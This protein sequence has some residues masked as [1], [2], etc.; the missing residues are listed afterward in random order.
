MPLRG[1][2][3][4]SHSGRF[5]RIHAPFPRLSDFARRRRA[6][7]FAC[8]IGGAVGSSARSQSDD[9]RTL[10]DSL[11]GP[12]PIDARPLAG[13]PPRATLDAGFAP[14]G[15][16]WSGSSASIADAYRAGRTTPEELVE[17]TLRAARAL[18][19]RSP[20][21]GPLL[22]YATRRRA[23][24]RRRNGALAS[25]AAPRAS[26][27]A[28]RRQGNSLSAGFP[29]AVV[30]TSAILR[31]APTTLRPHFACARAAPSSSASPP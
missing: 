9:L 18:A 23:R 11:R 10:P 28:H 16:P 4:D 3:R 8:R 29:G 31:C 21:M 27:G 20:S 14:P 17:K 19:A 12:F 26:T 7:P 25:R 5:I 15:P 24:K 1:S 2:S 13:R 6:G 22:A 30:Q